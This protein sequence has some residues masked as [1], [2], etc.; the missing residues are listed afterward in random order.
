MTVVQEAIE[1]GGGDYG[2]TEHGAPLADAAIAG[3]QDG[4]PLVATADELEE[5]VFSTR[6]RG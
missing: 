3:D 6:A 4:T 1:D 5:E 2:I